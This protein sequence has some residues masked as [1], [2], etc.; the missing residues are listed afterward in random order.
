M[1]AEQ[2]REREPQ[3]FDGLTLRCAKCGLYPTIT[4][5]E[6]EDAT[7]QLQALGVAALIA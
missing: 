6:L 3:E 4:R 2:V 5:S 7:P 1:P